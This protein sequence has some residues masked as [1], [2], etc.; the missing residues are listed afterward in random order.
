MSEYNL[1]SAIQSPA[2][3]KALEVSRLDEL[4][5]EIRSFLI[6][7]VTRTGGH[8]SSN[9]GV[10]E[11]TVALH[12]VFDTTK[13][14]LIWDVG[15]QSYVHKMLT[16]RQSGFKKLRLKGGLSG[17]P[18]PS[19]SEHDTIHAGHS[20][21]SLSIAAGIAQA[22][23]LKGDKSATIAL[24]GDG[25]FT[26][27]IVY[28]ALNNI[29]HHKL[30]V[31]IIL[32]DNGMSISENVGGMNNYLNQMRT[33][34]AYIRFK[35]RLESMVG[36]IPGLGGPL[37]KA[38][39]NVKES[40]KDTFFPGRFFHDI[41]LD[42]Y[43][44]SDGHN[45]EEL[46]SLFELVKQ[47]EHPLL[48]HVFTRKGKG[49]E[50][51]EI[52]PCSFHGISGISI[53]DDDS[54]PVCKSGVSYSQ[55]FG[56]LMCRQAEK[57]SSVYA[58]TA[59]MTTG[60]GLHDFAEKFPARFMDVGIAEQHAV[61]FALGLALKGF[62]PVVAIYSTFLQRAFD[63]LVHDVGISEK[64][65]VFCLDR[66]GLVPNDG[67]T[68]QGVFDISFLRLIP[69]FT[70]LLPA[71]GTEFEMMLEYA[72]HQCTGPVA[73]RYPKD[74]VLEI[75][76]FNIKTESIKTGRGVI[77]AEGSSAILVS[78]GTLL[79]EAV[80]CRHLLE[81]DEISLEI[82]NLRFAKPINSKELE[83]LSGDDRPVFILE[84]GVYSGGIAQFLENEI[85]TRNPRKYVAAITIP[86]IFPGIDTR[87][88][89]LSNYGLTAKKISFRIKNSLN[90]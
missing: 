76:E 46:T 4:C 21:T 13:D 52:D 19:E 42:Y 9:L 51:A 79:Q 71:C 28:E 16:G 40:I 1:L 81:K 35:K 87:E 41:G 54:I 70:I 50:E 15:H 12:R 59:A 73:I 61:D 3:L 62:K 86:D 64:H 49:H 6:E 66:S 17:F 32:N 85:K 11:L 90:I 56:E 72:L 68:H 2:E 8:L 82:L 69:G 67:P 25:A 30:P 27:G 89:L 47:H 77:V 74:I 45:I 88:G 26:A 84:E 63:M 34:E 44:P 14:N 55:L 18:H 53:S 43:G 48:L 7:N 38:L 58:I 39:Y 10:V 78:T 23:R 80:N 60:T 65:I 24:I 75:P 33:S 5:Q 83:Y 20:S 22:K 37:K 31:L 57:D 29:A 36:A